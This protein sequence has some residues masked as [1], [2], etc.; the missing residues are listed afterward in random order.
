[1]ASRASISLSLRY[2]VL[3]RDKRTCQYCG[4]RSPEVVLELD[5]RIPVSKGGT[6]DESNLVTACRECNR[7]KS[8]SVHQS[9]EDYQ[10]RK[11][12]EVNAVDAGR[13]IHHMQGLASGIVK[14]LLQ[15][16][17][18]EL[19]LFQYDYE[20][21]EAIR[22]FADLWL[23]AFLDYPSE[24]PANKLMNFANA[25]GL[26]AFLPDKKPST[27]QRFLTT[28]IVGLQFSA[29]GYWAGEGDD[30]E[31]L[32]IIVTVVHSRDEGE[33]CFGLR[34]EHEDTDH[35][36]TVSR[37][38]TLIEE[39]QSMYVCHSHSWDGPSPFREW[40]P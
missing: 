9:L 7:G 37:L 8:D 24:E 2:K 28:R 27:F 35:A 3:E 11:I 6:N 17:R 18:G 40:Q 32:D 19:I 1:M 29:H 36:R 31:R 14:Y 39:L 16:G 21:H 22:N 20:F 10:V 30:E 15:D 26:L 38:G 33:D 4:R 25:S 23:A 12:V 34:F 5:H 13:D